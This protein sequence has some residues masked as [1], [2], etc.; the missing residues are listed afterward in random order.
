MLICTG[1]LCLLFIPKFVA[2]FVSDEQAIG[3]LRAFHPH[4]ASD[5]SGTESENSINPDGSKSD[6]CGAA[7]SAN[8]A[9]KLKENKVKGYRVYFRS[10]S[11]PIM[12]SKWRSGKMYL[13]HDRKRNYLMIGISDPEDK[14]RG[15]SICLME[16]GCHIIQANG[17]DHNMEF[18]ISAKLPDGF[19]YDFELEQRESFEL[20]RMALYAK[21]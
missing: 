2:I 3:K 13:V 7:N 21:N 10:G 19:Y 1:T 11:N 18:K 17:D 6:S 8:L 5:E 12:M 14:F 4:S 16:Q 15:L 9:V 20:L